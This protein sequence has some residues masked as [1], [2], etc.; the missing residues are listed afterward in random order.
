MRAKNVIFVNRAL[1]PHPL[2][3]SGENSRIRT[4][5]TSFDVKLL[6]FIEKS[7]EK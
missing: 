3:P 5:A 4:Y 6:T 1:S 2:T 7:T